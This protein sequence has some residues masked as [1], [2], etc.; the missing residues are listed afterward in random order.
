MKLEQKKPGVIGYARVSTREQSENHHALEQQQSRLK[1][2]GAEIIYT[3][4]ESGA[5]NDRP[6]FNKVLKL[7]REGIIKIIIATRWDR[8]T[9]NEVLYLQLKEILRSYDITLKLLDQGEV[10]LN[11]ASGEL[12]ADMSA[13]FAVHERRMIRERVK[14][15]MAYRRQGKKAWMRQPWGYTIKDDD[16][17]ALDTR[18]IVCSLEDRPQ[19][20]LSL[21]SLPD[22]S[23]ELAGVSKAEI[24]REALSYFFQV[25][26]PRQVLKYL[27]QKYG[28]RRK[29]KTN[30]VLTEELLFW[31]SGQNFADWLK[32]PVLRGHTAYCKYNNRRLKASEQ[33]EIHL[34]TH[35]EQVLL[36]EEEFTEAQ[37]IL[38]SNARKVGTPG[39]KFYLTGLVF[40]DSCGYK[41]VLKRGPKFSYYGC[42]QSNIGCDNSKCVRLE[43]LDTAIISQLFTK[44][45]ELNSP[46]AEEKVRSESPEL[47]KL[48]EQLVGLEKLLEIQPTEE[49][50]EAKDKIV[51]K[52]EELLNPKNEDFSRATAQ[53]ILSYPYA[54]HLGFW[55][56]LSLEEREIIYEKLIKRVAILDGKV[57][58]V[59][60]QI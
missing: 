43:Q 18:P 32:N 35:P 46:I 8:L 12:S 51:R 40:C 13:I 53:Q 24:A 22:D 27:Y 5:N 17:Y 9:R 14:R 31:S 48:K 7:A 37:D 52:I 39:A 26:R 1:Q 29:N 25:R 19:N 10:D 21:A 56:T 4:V 59:E 36:T 34:N 3:D 49:I 45:I 58:S 20:H 15:G 23:P 30:L 6:E 38:K 57:V 54:K 60:L 50:K 44:A 11:S 55:Y 33:W 41:C 2:A 47:V 28:A 16:K 42:R